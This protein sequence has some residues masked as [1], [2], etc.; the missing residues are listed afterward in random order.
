MKAIKILNKIMNKYF[1]KYNKLF[2]KELNQSPKFEFM[3][4][5]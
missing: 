2:F 5:I 4:N 3:L 1:R